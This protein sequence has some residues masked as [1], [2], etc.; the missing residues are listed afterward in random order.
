MANGYYFLGKDWLETAKAWKKTKQLTPPVL[1]TVAN[2]AHTAARVEYAFTHKRINIEE[3]WS[4]CV[5]YLRLP[6]AHH[7]RSRTTIQLERLNGEGHRRTKVI[8]RFPT[9]TMPI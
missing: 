3:L 9:D 4:E 5:T 2:T 8:P 7:H 6:A 1:I